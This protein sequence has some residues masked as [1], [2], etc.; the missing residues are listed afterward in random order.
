MSVPVKMKWFTA[1]RSEARKNA[2]PAGSESF[3][4]VI[5]FVRLR[6]GFRMARARPHGSVRSL[7]VKFIFSVG[8]DQTSLAAEIGQLETLLLEQ[9][10][11]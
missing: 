2:P 3:Y 6:P 11:N 7:G 1:R 9:S 4:G 8:R 5:Q 10:R